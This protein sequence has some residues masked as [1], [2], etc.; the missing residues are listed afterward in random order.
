MYVQTAWKKV[1]ITKACTLL[2][3]SGN[4]TPVI[5]FLT[6]GFLF[7]GFFEKRCS[8]KHQN[9]F[10]W[11]NAT[12]S[13]TAVKPAQEPSVSIMTSHLCSALPH[14]PPS[15]LTSLTFHPP[16]A[17]NDHRLLQS[18]IP[19]SLHLPLGRSCMSTSDRLTTWCSVS[20]KITLHEAKAW[21][22]RFD[23]DTKARRSLKLIVLL[24]LSVRQ[25]KNQLC[26]EKWITSPYWLVLN[27]AV[28]HWSVFSLQMFGWGTGGGFLWLEA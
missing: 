1:G 15:A 16:A 22:R 9:V 20:L 2:I 10:Y 7:F 26:K 19:S 28:C 12:R 17:H 23:Y 21:K 13:K 27:Y 24:T 18:P 11:P 8:V 14:N 6:W 3:L 5:I 4:S 25:Q